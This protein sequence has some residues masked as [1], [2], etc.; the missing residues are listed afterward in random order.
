MPLPAGRT[1]LLERGGGMD[2]PTVPS[3]NLIRRADAPAVTD[4]HVDRRSE[5]EHSRIVGSIAPVDE[6]PESGQLYSLLQART[7]TKAKFL[8]DMAN[9]GPAEAKLLR[10]Q[11]LPGSAPQVQPGHLHR[12]FPG[13]HRLDDELS[14]LTIRPGEDAGL[15]AMRKRRRIVEYLKDEAGLRGVEYR[16]ALDA[17]YASRNAATEEAQTAAEEA[18][19]ASYVK[20]RAVLD[21]SRH[22]NK[23]LEQ[24]VGDL[25]LAFA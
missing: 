9:D 15:R 10:S 2:A 4:D 1:A 20:F 7:F 11:S 12:H 16:T 23:L 18:R 13:K 17:D 8:V 22:Q 25:R 21:R 5:S 3:A 24:H 19:A 6:I 14:G